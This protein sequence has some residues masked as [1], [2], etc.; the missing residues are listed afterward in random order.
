MSMRFE[1]GYWERGERNKVGSL[2]ENSVGLC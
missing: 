2:E 1:E